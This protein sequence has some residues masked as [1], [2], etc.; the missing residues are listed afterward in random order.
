VLVFFKGSFTNSKGKQW[1]KTGWFLWDRLRWLISL[2]HS[3]H[4]LKLALG[5]FNYMHEVWSIFIF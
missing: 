1:K 3:A 2:I 5:Y 4:A